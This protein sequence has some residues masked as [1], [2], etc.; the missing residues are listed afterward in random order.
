MTDAIMPQI[1]NHCVTV[2]EA[3]K[4]TAEV[5]TDQGT[6]RRVWRGFLTKLINEDCGLAVP[7]YSAVR[8][9]LVRMGCIEQINRG[10]GTHPSMWELIKNPTEQLFLEKGKVRTNSKTAV[11]EGQISDLTAR[12]ERVENMLKNVGDL[13]A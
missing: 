2:Y 3:M 10:G 5:I 6:P 12:L 13:S 9:N 1:Y 8:N 11:M 7:Y 4:A